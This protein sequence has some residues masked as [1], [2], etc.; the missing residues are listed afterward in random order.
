MALL[1]T[2]ILAVYRADNQTN[3]KATVSQIV[4]RVPA[5]TA[6]ALNAVL[7]TGNTSDNIDIIVRDV[8]LDE[9]VKLTAIAPSSFKLGLTSDGDV[10]IGETVKII[11]EPT[12]VVSGNQVDLFGNITDGTAFA[13][14]EVGTTVDN[15]VTQTKTVQITNTGAANFNGPLEAESID[16]GVYATDE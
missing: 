5:P 16:G 15:K 8:N 9:Q 14:Y 3:Y 2:D 12:G 6:P 1:D 7:S 13:V 11:L 10:K 4:A